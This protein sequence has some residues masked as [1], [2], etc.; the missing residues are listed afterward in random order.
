ML[1]SCNLLCVGE[2][3]LVCA[4]VCWTMSASVKAH[5]THVGQS[6]ACP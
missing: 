5:H 6:F 1:H 2:A 4:V 3:L